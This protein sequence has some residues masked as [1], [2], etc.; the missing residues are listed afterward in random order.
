MLQYP[1]VWRRVLL[2]V[3]K[4]AIEN[5]SLHEVNNDNGVKS[6]QLGHIQKSY[7]QKYNVPTL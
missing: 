3:F 2:R 5:E 6:S 1:G 7:Y 4:P